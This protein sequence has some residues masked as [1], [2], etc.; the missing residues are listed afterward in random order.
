MFFFSGSWNGED[1]KYICFKID[2]YLGGL[3]KCKT[4][5]VSIMSL[6][7]ADVAL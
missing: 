3:L 1:S 5:E 4:M 2:I 7:N 6:I